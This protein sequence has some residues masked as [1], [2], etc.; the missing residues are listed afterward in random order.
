MS[1][2]FSAANSSSLMAP[3]T[4]RLARFWSCPTRSCAGPAVVAGFSSAGTATGG[5]ADGGGGEA[6]SGIIVGAEVLAGMA[7]VA[8]AAGTWRC[9][10]VG[11]SVASSSSV[12][13]A[14]LAGLASWFSLASSCVRTLAATSSTS[15]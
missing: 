3:L 9:A 11:A 1:L 5:V 14:S 10:D 4:C 8:G 12:L 15:S 7:R 13:R 6:G 2:A